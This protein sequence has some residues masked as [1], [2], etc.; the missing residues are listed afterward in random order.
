MGKGQQLTRQER[1][2]IEQGMA[3]VADLQQQLT[4]FVGDETGY[5]N[6]IEIFDAMPKFIWARSRTKEDLPDSVMTRKFKLRD[7]RYIARIKP[8]LVEKKING[9]KKSVLIYP[10]QREEIVE[11]VLR[12][13]AYN[14][15]AVDIQGEAGVIFTISGL[16]RE[17]EACG[18][19]M[20]YEEVMEALEVLGSANLECIPEDRDG[21]VIRGSYLGSM[22]LASRKDYLK[23]PER[24]RCFA[25]FHPLVTLSIR[26]QTYRLYDYEKAMSITNELARYMYK[27]MSHYYTYA[28]PGK[29]YG[30]K[31]KSFLSGTPRGL[32]K[33]MKADLEAMRRALKWLIEKEIVDSYQEIMVKNPKDRRSTL[34]AEYVVEPHPTFVKHVI[35]ANVK[36]KAVKKQALKLNEMALR[37]LKKADEDDN[38]G[39]GN[40]IEVR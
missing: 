38:E 30:F 16:R 13:I 10:A 21:E 12:K 15:D 18:H 6:T 5:S 14:G 24:A 32:S 17:L 8:A 25:G 7:V 11:E 34:D 37:E 9:K 19:G 36:Q 22:Y 33:R 20:T 4:L 26:H 23:D 2:A 1:E 28:E 40:L 31:L 27:R 35:A 29:P 3:P 39:T